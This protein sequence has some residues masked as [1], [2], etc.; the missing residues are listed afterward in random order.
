M[1]LLLHCSPR[2]DK[3]RGSQPIANWG[4]V[5]I[6]THKNME[7]STSYFLFHSENLK[8]GFLIIDMTSRSA[9][10]IR[11]HTVSIDH[12][13]VV[14][15]CLKDLTPTPFQTLQK[16]RSSS[17]LK[18]LNETQ[19]NSVKITT[20]TQFTYTLP[21]SFKH[22]SKSCAPISTFFMKNKKKTSTYNFWHWQKVKLM[23]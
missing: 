3:S 17:W 6:R 10:T 8:M 12:M 19:Q 1:K 5:L 9:S 2:R 20:N 14:I 11:I 21:R 16:W 18:H 4:Q 7:K 22:L 23:T 13:E 15:Q